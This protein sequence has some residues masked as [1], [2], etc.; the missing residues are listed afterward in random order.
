M[1]GTVMVNDFKV[2]T[3]QWTT[4][5]E[6]LNSLKRV[7]SEIID[8]GFYQRNPDTMVAER[9]PYDEGAVKEGRYHLGITLKDPTTKEE[10]TIYVDG[11]D[12]V[13]DLLKDLGVDPV[14]TF[15]AF[16][17]LLNVYKDAL[18]LYGIWVPTFV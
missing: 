4:D 9:V 12:N 5:E 11:T 14:N 1:S 8:I 10:A 17:K 16:G 13:K 3:G 15:P 2:H 6:Q 7:T 18:T